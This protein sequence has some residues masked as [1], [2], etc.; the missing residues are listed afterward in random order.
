M[1]SLPVRQAGASGR[2]LSTFGGSS[3]GK[4]FT[5]IFMTLLFTTAAYSQSNDWN[6]LNFEC[7]GYVTE[8]IPVKYPST[9]GRSINDQVLYART[10]IGGIYRSSNNG[11]S[12]DYVST[13]LNYPADGQPGISGSELSIQ[14]LAVRYD[15]VAQKEI[16][17]VAWGNYEDDA[18]NSEFGGRRYQSIWRSDNSGAQ[19]SW[20][21]AEI[22]GQVW[23]RG[24][25]FPV[26]IGGPCITYDPNNNPNGPYNMYM[27]GFGP[28]NGKAY[29]YKSENDGQSWSKVLSFEQFQNSSGFNGE[30]I[31]YISIK[32][33]N[34]HHIWVGTTNGI[35]FTTNGGVNW[36]RVSIPGVST[37]YVKRILLRK[38]GSIITGAMVTWGKNKDTTGIGRLLT[39]NWSYEPLNSNFKSGL[40]PTPSDTGSSLYSALAFVDSLENVVMAGK[41]SRPFRKTTNFGFSW[42]GDLVHPD[43]I[44]FWYD[45]A[46]INNIPK[47][48]NE[49]QNHPI[50][51]DY[52]SYSGMTSLVKNPNNGLGNQWYMSGGK[53]ARMTTR[54]ISHPDSVSASRWKYTVFGQ[55]MTV[56]YDVVFNTVNY[57]GYPNGRK[58]IY[59]PLSDWTMGWT[60]QDRLNNIVSNGMISDALSYDRQKTFQSN[61]SD[62]YI[63]NVIRILI[64]PD[65]PNLSYCVGGSV[66]GF[67]AENRRA[68]FYV[69]TLNTNGTFTTERNTTHQFLTDNDRAIVD[70]IIYKKPDNVNRII[71]LVG[72]NRASYPPG[73]TI[74]LFYSDNGGVSWSQGTFTVQSGV[75]G[76]QTMQAYNNSLIPGLRSGLDGSIGDLF[77]G[78]FS[79]SYAGGSLVYLWLQSD[80]T[81]GSYGGGLFISTDN[82]AN[83][84]AGADIDSGNIYWGAGSLKYIGNDRLALAFRDFRTTPKGLYIGSINRANNGSVS[85]AEF[86]VVGPTR[87]AS[88]EHLD[89]NLDR[90]VVYGKRDGDLYNQIYLSINNGNWQRIGP[91]TPQ[92]LPGVKSLRIRPDKN[93]IWVATGGQGVWK[94]NDFDPRFTVKDVGI[95]TGW[96]MLSVPLE[97]FDFR[98]NSV[99]NNRIPSTSV[100]TYDNGNYII[101]DSLTNGIGY[102]V[103]YS[104]SQNIN[105]AGLSKSF[106]VPV[107]AGWNMIGS[108][109]QNL[110]KSKIYSNPENLIISNFYGYENSYHNADTIKSG[111]GYWVKANLSGTITLDRNSTYSRTQYQCSDDSL[112]NPSGAPPIPTLVS[113]TNGSTGISN[114]PTL[115]WKRPESTSLTYRLQISTNS[116]Y[117]NLL[118]DESSISDTSIQI[119]LSYNTK[120]Y[121][122]V[123]ATNDVTTSS[124]SNT[125]NFITRSAPQIDPCDPVVSSLSSLDK[126]TVRGADGNSQDMFIRNGAKG[127][128]LGISDFD[129]PPYPPKNLFN[130][131]FQS[132]KF[133]ETILPN[134]KIKKMPIVIK[135][136]QYPVEISWDVKDA[137]NINYWIY[138]PGSNNEKVSLSGKGKLSVPNTSNDIL[139]VEA[140]AALPRPCE[141]YKISTEENIPENFSLYQNYPNPFN[142]TTIIKYD[143]PENSYV[144]LKIYDVLGREVAKLVEEYQEAGYKSVEFDALNLTSGVYF[145]KL[146]AGNYTSI[147]K[148]LLLR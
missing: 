76:K 32:E 43:K 91:L 95:N 111:K 103:K 82:G 51:P 110:P 20:S 44:R 94:F 31:T 28:N 140:Q 137:N 121:W 134:G 81:S 71:A 90:W 2:R 24:N 69:R 65:N 27:G 30:G 39:P 40:D 46:S 3:S 125:W 119:G 99:Y 130:A 29:L 12:W 23:F 48:S 97:I 1:K 113:P 129:M 100:F 89:V 18:F 54:G 141:F 127:I 10:D 77:N 80:T 93:E 57:T 83:W 147:K 79:L 21:K 148:M 108:V 109:D 11:L 47:H 50:S 78:H 16:V 8:I 9:A 138:K 17:N 41:E 133:I 117:T 84:G 106:I 139:F 126:F 124:W 60:Y 105:Y 62:T 74:G 142:P 5:I 56:N 120:Y 36:N 14:G 135:H 13:Y 104:S 72:G 25:N 116:C 114:Y 53:G 86:G 64:D 55:A 34:P 7:G 101:S 136:A 59:L 37:P 98:A 68:G 107:K 131:R 38:E 144:N 115:R 88:A 87:F 35:V 145:Y 73:G 52:Q 112:P 143:L 19:L 102:W 123:T 63:S 42:T 122:R 85:W 26:K 96:N 6:Y 49:A 61:L 146:Y 33:G 118:Y 75:M 128:N 66:Y 4:H 132:D 70:A 45:D 15:S 22:T 92:H 67:T 58:A